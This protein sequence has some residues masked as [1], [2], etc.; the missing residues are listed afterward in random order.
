MQ[1]ICKRGLECTFAHGV[2]DMQ[3]WDARHEFLFQHI[4]TIFNFELKTPLLGFCRVHLPWQQ[5]DVQENLFE[6][7]APAQL[8]G[9]VGV[10]KALIYQTFVAFRREI[11]ATDD[12][13]C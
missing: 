8:P 10:A 11:A 1:G 4:S 7:L 5:V 13:L 3:V 12:S 6:D 9:A 2:E